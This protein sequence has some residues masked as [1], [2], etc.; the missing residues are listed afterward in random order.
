M[1]ARLFLLLSFLLGSLLLPARAGTAPRL[2][3]AP[4]SLRA[5]LRAA[6]TPAARTQVWLRVANA[7]GAAGDSAAL[8]YVRAVLRQAQQ[9]ADSHLRGQGLQSLGTYYLLANDEQKA[10]PPLEEAGRLL[11][12]APPLE[13]GL[14][15]LRL[16]DVYDMVDR[17]ALALRS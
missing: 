14:N 8:G 11:A 4:D 1:A 12:T 9:T 16:G 17:P 13:R 7:Y 3:P 15:L 10:L 6:T 2:A 5:A